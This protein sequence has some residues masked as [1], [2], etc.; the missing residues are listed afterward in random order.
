VPSTGGTLSRR[1]VHAHGACRE[2]KM[3]NGYAL[4]QAL[5]LQSP[6]AAQARSDQDL[7]AAIAAGDKLALRTLFARHH[8]RTYRFVLRIIDDT[9]KAEDIV[10]E[11][12]FDV[13]RKAGSF[14]GRSKVSTWILAI[15][16]FKAVSVLRQRRYEALSDSMTQALVD[17]RDDPECALQ[18]S[19][20]C[21]LLQ[22]CL[23]QLSPK[24][25]EII[26]LVYY[27]EMSV[28]EA[29][30]ILG[31]PANTVKTRM[32]YARKQLAEYFVQA[33]GC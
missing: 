25:R 12:F 2:A 18:K 1:M 5:A 30:E 10:S 7:L 26:D 19:D 28:G 14:K 17:E 33:R 29:A 27:Q 15:A 4:T 16:R 21:S 11:V 20:D 23:R 6:P 31:V 24:H 32:F 3:Q 9:S 22:G 8:I 13:W